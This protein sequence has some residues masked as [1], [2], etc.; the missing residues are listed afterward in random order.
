MRFRAFLAAAILIISS[1]IP[2]VVSAFSISP[3]ILELRGER[4]QTIETKISI[5]NTD[6]REKTYYLRTLSFSAKNGQE[7]VPEFVPADVS[8]SELA[9]W[10]S[11]SSRSVLIP[12]RANREIPFFVAIPSDI[13]SGGYQAAVLVSD[14]P[15]EAVASS[16]ATLQAS[17]AT[18]IFLTVEG[19]NLAKADLVDFTS[20]KQGRPA[21]SAAGS[22]S[23]RIQNQG[24]VYIQPEG[25]VVVK[26]VF[27]R[28]LSVADANPARGRVLAGT[29]RKFDG[30]FGSEGNRM[31][32]FGP[33]TAEL[34]LQYGGDAILRE[35]IRFWMISPGFFVIVI[36]L[37]GIEVIRRKL[38]KNNRKSKARRRLSA[39]ERPEGGSRGLGES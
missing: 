13:S 32:A 12:A 2:L 11:F 6:N 16:G 19:Q 25:T 36:L 35:K 7:G 1:T 10:I 26:D 29:T 24:N 21:L 3:A 9:N 18:L 28:V 33:I 17:I 30:E 14:A 37:I 31:W 38:M 39:H 20:T 23:Y 4:G 5:F 27:G 15:S 22:F 8:D 34:R